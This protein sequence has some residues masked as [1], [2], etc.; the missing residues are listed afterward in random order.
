[1]QRRY[2]GQENDNDNDGSSYTSTSSSTV[3]VVSEHSQLLP[4]KSKQHTRDTTYKQEFKWLCTNSSPIIVT[5]LLQNSFQLASIFVLGHIGPVEL[6]AS[7]LGGM[8]A[9]VTAWSVALGATTALDTLLSQAWTGATDKT[10]LGIHL[11][12]ALMILVLM[13]I[14]ISIVWWNA[15][16]ILLYLKQ[17]H[18]VAYYTGLFMRYLLIGA[19]A[20]IAFEAI[21]KFL[22]AQGIMHGSTY[23]LL[24]ASPINFG[25]NYLFVHTFSF[26]FIGAPLATSCSYWLMFFLLLGYIQ[27]LGYGK[28]GW[29]GW[30]WKESRKD[31]MVFMR[32]AIPGMLVVMSEWWAF[33]VASL[34]ASYLGTLDLAAQSIVM[35]L[36][37]C[38]YTIPYGLGVA[39]ANRVG[40]ALGEANGQKARHATIT[41]IA[42]GIG[43]AVLNSTV[44]LLLRNNI[45][46]LFSP[47]KQVVALVAQ[48]LPL[49]AFFQIADSLASV[50]G[51]IMRGL[52]RQHISA[53]V[54]LIAYYCVA[55]PLGFYL[56]FTLHYGLLGLWG[57]LS[58]ALF[59]CAFG[60]SISLYR[61]HWQYEA[62][63][64]H[65]RVRQEEEVL[66]YLPS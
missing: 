55:L 32:L 3:S 50:C 23:C 48:V 63:K 18:E 33:E 9:S 52:A 7:A 15:T 17:D 39:V 59:L 2:D 1:M 4:C 57:G 21:K 11:Q 16:I 51:G 46:F 62:N 26:G 14:P 36:S 43:L 53:N 64:A 8:F 56:T 27:V 45:G 30:N 25:L 44:L 47:D 35:T 20:Y 38:T 10:L 60:Q 61:V 40:N 49:L 12:R 42:F 22:Q 34:A 29:G 54:N 24:I 31:W 28:E 58:I 37:S 13:F 6:G 66:F 41:A 19:P 5:Y 65:H